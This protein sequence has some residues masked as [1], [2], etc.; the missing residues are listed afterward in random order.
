MKKNLV[1]A[2]Y[3]LITFMFTGCAATQP[4]E[5]LSGKIKFEKINLAFIQKHYPT[6]KQYQTE[7]DVEQK[8][9]DVIIKN[10]ELNNML[11]ANSTDTLAISIMFR[12][13]FMGEG[14]PLESL[15]SDTIGSPKL[16][17]DI[18]IMRNGKVL[19]R[20]E[21]NNLIYDAGLFG[22]MKHI[23]LM[24]KEN[25]RENGAIEALGR[26]IVARVKEFY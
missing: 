10:L 8:L 20:L 14:M 16:A 2:I 1:Y 22:N 7:K 17:Y 11:D 12:R 13:I 6:T 26:D 25:E 4:S 19:R 21:K 9:N 15:K 18:Q 3:I 5:P 24:D 23:M